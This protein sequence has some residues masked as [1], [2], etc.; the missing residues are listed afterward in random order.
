MPCTL[1]NH[2]NNMCVLIY[3]PAGVTMP[4][5]RILKA[6]F[7]ANPHGAGFATPDCVHHSMRFESIYKGLKSV[8]KEMPCIIHFRLATHG[9][10]RLRNCHPFKIEQTYFAHNGVL[11]LPTKNDMTDSE[12]A[13]RMLYPAI[14]R[15]GLY[16][17]ELDRNV[18]Q[19]IGTSKFAFMCGKDVRLFGDFKK[20]DGVY[21]S[22][23][24]WR[25][26]LL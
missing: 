25:K 17:Q 9:S 16:S 15:G 2:D 5:K 1:T 13:F 23:L 26:Y 18:R 14:K 4:A 21:Y 22:N 19:I 6:C 11:S 3:K 10:I 24:R 7:D 8:P 20:I 12:T